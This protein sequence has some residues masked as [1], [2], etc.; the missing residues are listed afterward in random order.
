MDAGQEQDF[1]LE[2][3][4][5][6]REHPL[7]EEHVRDRLAAAS[8]HP[9]HGFGAIERLREQVGAER[10]QLAMPIEIA[11]GEQFGDR[12]IE[13]DAARLG[14]ADQDPHVSRRP[15]PARA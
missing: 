11:A 5:D 14:G 12:D 6:T 3:V 9:P 15:L 7:V 1:R 13:T 8:A 10:L 4:A 2:Y